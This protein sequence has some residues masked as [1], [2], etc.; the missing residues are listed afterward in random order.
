MNELYISDS[1]KDVLRNL[2]EEY[3]EMYMVN[4]EELES[5]WHLMDYKVCQ[6]LSRFN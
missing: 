2:S 1:N 6:H 3:E 5:N 4:Y